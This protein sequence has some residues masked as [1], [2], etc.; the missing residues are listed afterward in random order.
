LMLM[1]WWWGKI[2]WTVSFSFL[3]CRFLLRY[4]RWCCYGDFLVLRVFSSGWCLLVLDVGCVTMLFGWSE[5]G[6]FEVSCISMVFLM[7]SKQ[8]DGTKWIFLC[9]TIWLSLL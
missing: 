9:C 5:L 3:F 2:L 8:N 1:G 4:G 6:S 7:H